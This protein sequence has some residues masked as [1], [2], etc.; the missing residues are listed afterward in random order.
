MQ[1]FYVVGIGP[2]SFEQLTPQAM[3]ALLAADVIAGYGAYIKLVQPL[4]PKK[5][6][7]QTGMT[8]EV[9]RCQLALEQAKAGR[10]VA[11]ISSGD[12]GV[13]GMA[14]LVMQLAAEIC[15]EVEV[16]AV[17]GITAA[18]SGA[19]L[20]GAPL[21][22][23]FAVVSLSDRLTPWEKIARRL[24]A[25]AAADFCLVL[26]NPRSHGRPDLLRQACEIISEA[27]QGEAAQ[28]GQTPVG[29]VKNIGREGEQ[30]IV[31]TL[32]DLDY[33]LVDMFSTVF[34][35]NSQTFIQQTIGGPRIVT[36]RGYLPA[37]RGE[38]A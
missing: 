10:T 8:G 30:T 22:H 1:K 18:S 38:Q 20:L 2:G 26:Y 13:Y 7:L 29:I 24:Q 6:Y 36:P 21:M 31:T 9:K 33:E 12:A 28:V 32:A 35:G 34:I 15:P 11:M 23:D 16:V 3:A 25:A 14:G 27:K 4:F 19:A 5:E 37:D 17:P